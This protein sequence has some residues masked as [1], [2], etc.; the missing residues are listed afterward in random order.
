MI[1]IATAVLFFILILY[2]FHVNDGLNAIPP[3]ALKQSPYRWTVSEIKS[4]FERV[5][6]NPIDIRPY[7]PP[8]KDRRYIVF[9]GSGLIGG[10]IVLQ[11]LARGQPPESIRIIDFRKPV[12]KDLLRGDALKVGFVQ[13]DVT[14]QESVRLAF[15]K[16]WA[17]SVSSLPLT[18]FHTAAIILP[19]DRAQILQSRL[20]S[21]NTVG[22]AHV[23]AVARAAGAN[24]FIATSSG[25]ISVRPCNFWI[26]P[27]QKWSPNYVQFYPDPSKDLNIRPRNEYSGNY[28]ISKADAEDLVC[29]ANDVK[30]GFQTGCIR[31]ACGVYGNR[32]D[33][34]VGTYM[35]T[36]GRS[37]T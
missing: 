7:L 5:K 26:H 13:A 28:S 14:Q 32:Y 8:K 34:T 36:V 18:V 27:W 9:G 37:P 15:K 35:S 12:R 17:S 20:S 4:T 11:L 2:L 30:G 21:V 24:V 29:K 10:A 22:T 16:P 33:M 6:K 1:L 3:E 25:S 31:P 19:G 23:L